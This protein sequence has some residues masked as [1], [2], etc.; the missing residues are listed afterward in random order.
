MASLDVWFDNEIQGK[1]RAT[2]FAAGLSG[3]QAQDQVELLQAAIG[4]EMNYTGDEIQ[5]AVESVADAVDGG[6][7][8]R[9]LHSIGH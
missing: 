9:F 7:V 5:A 8:S 1:L 3:E 4:H 6:F 2:A